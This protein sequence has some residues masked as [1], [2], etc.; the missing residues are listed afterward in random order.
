MSNFLYKHKA[1]ETKSKMYPKMKNR[2]PD[3]FNK[4][5]KDIILII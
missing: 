3:Y 1:I 2:S 5:A 4:T